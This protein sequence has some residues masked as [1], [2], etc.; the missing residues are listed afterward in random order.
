MNRKQLLTNTEIKHVDFLI[1]GIGIGLIPLSVITGIV[2]FIVALF[3]LHKDSGP[4]Q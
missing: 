4:K 3:L 2:L 1:M